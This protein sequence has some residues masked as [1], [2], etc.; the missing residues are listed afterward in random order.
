M[1]TLCWRDD[2]RALGIMLVDDHAVFRSGLRRRFEPGGSMEVVAEADSG[3][4]A[5]QL[6]GEQLPSVVSD[7]S[8][9]GM[10]GLGRCGASVALSG[11]TYRGVF[12]HE[13]AAA[14]WPCLGARGYAVKSGIA[15]DLTPRAMPAGK[16]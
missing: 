14:T 2:E 13:T 9:P 1:E 16:I 15:D 6:Y 4:S 3:E 8:M 5:Y 10:G 11:S 12:M 7:M